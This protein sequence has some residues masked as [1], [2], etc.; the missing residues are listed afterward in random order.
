MDVRLFG[1]VLALCCTLLLTVL[2]PPFTSG[3]PLDTTIDLDTTDVSITPDLANAISDLLEQRPINDFPGTI[4][5]VTS[6][7]TQD[8]W[9][10]LGVVSLDGQ[11]VDPHA[12]GAGGLSK[13]IVAQQ[14]ADGSWQAAID[15]QSTFADLAAQTP[16]TLLESDSKSILGIETTTSTATATVASLSA[17]PDSRTDNGDLVIDNHESTFTF[18]GQ[19]S[20]AACGIGGTTNWT[21]AS[22]DTDNVTNDVAGVWRPNIPQ[23][24]QYRVLAHIPTCSSPANLTTNARY[25]IVHASGKSNVTI[26]QHTQRGWIDL[27]TF[28]FNTGTSGYARLTDLTSENFS[29]KRAV[30]FDA[31]QWVPPTESSPAPSPTPSATPSPT[32]S[33][34]PLPLSTVNYKFPWP[35]GQSWSWYQGWHNSA[36]DLGSTSSDRRILAAAEGTITSV[37]SCEIST[38]I[39]IKHADGEVF[40]YIHLDKYKINFDRIKVGRTVPQGLVLGELKP[41][42]WQD[43]KCGYTNQAGAVSHIHWVMP[44][45]RRMIFDGWMI[46]YPTNEWVQDGTIKTP[47]SSTRLTSTNQ[48]IPSF[49]LRTFIPGVEALTE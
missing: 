10:L 7:E 12:P 2:L 30:M 46:G 4:Y 33:P 8:E 1:R 3:A 43:G 49:H 19:I 32:P 25:E 47:G 28:T 45:N 5:R 41:D 35:A 6:V 24:G 16:S 36:H 26:N 18:A 44:V 11:S 15:G 20:E 17:S 29:E 42:T 37:Y 23:L 40:R 21:Y 48:P 38:I 39:D 22:N 9:A 34:T 13:L 31:I 14:R 27:G